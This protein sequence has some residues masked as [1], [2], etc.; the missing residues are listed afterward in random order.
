VRLLQPLGGIEGFL[1][2]TDLQLSSSGRLSD[3]PKEQFAGVDV[4]IA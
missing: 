1:Q 3:E 4:G 2:K